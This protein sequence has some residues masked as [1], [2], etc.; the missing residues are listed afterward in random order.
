MAPAAPIRL[1]FTVPPDKDAVNDPAP[2]RTT[3]RH[4]SGEDIHHGSGERTT[5]DSGIRDREAVARGSLPFRYWAVRL[6]IRY[7]CPE[8]LC[9]S[10]VLTVCC[11][12]ESVDR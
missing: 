1:I 11:R 6:S 7:A 2:G 12:T 9:R 4:R 8:D 10:A 3:A 5:A